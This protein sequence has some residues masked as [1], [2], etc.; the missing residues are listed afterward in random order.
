MMAEAM[1]MRRETIIE[2]ILAELYRGII[3]KICG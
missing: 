1:I 3:K 2:K